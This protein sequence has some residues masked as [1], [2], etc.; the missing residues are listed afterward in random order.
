MR[1]LKLNEWSN[2]ADIVGMIAIVAS[3]YFVIDSIERNTA[4][5]HA[6]NDNFLF[7]LQDS[8]LEAESTNQ[9]LAR[10]IIK[11][12]NGEKLSDIEWLQYESHIFRKINRW[13]ITFE[14]MSDGLLAKDAFEVWDNTFALEVTGQITQQNWQDWRVYYG[15]DFGSHV[16]RVFEAAER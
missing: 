4:T 13:E 11:R 3:L 9:N 8:D 5:L 2:I 10:V 6:S 15:K 1:K 14:R 7:Q 12:R 16:D